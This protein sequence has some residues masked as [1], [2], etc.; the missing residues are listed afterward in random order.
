MKILPAYSVT[1]SVYGKEKPEFLRRSIKSIMEQTHPTDD[2]IIVCDG[3]LTKELDEVLLQAQEKYNAIKIV[4]TKGHVGTAAAANMSLEMCKNE[5]IGKM[6]SDDIALPQRFEKQLRRMMLHP[7]LDIIG[8]YIEEFDSDTGGTIAIKKVPLCNDTVHEYAKRRNPFNNPTLLFK[9]SAATAAGGYS[10]DLAR[11]E[12]YDFVVKMLA[13]GAVGGNIPQ[14]LLKYRITQGNYER[15]RNFANTKAFI[16]ARWKIYR[17]GYSSLVD[18][19]IPC[20]AQ[21]ALFLLPSSMTGLIYRKA[22][23]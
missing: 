1:M 17:S 5:Y 4:R 10:E 6:D 2:F 22:M 7:E 11:C 8:G 23:R 20:A 9:K 13:N 15:R 12:D 3:E 21:V 18:F 16:A 14:V 19:I